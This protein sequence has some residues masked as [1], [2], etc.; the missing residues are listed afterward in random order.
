MVEVKCSFGS[1]LGIDMRS[2]S[3]G[4]RGGGAILEDV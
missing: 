1:A 2:Y 3:G 4:W